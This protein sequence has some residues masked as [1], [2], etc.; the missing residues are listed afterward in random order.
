MNRLHSI[1]LLLIL[2]SLFYLSTNVFGRKNNIIFTI[3]GRQ[4]K[5]NHKNVKYD[6]SGTL[7]ELPSDDYYEDNDDKRKFIYICGNNGPCTCEK[8]DEN[9]V[10]CIKQK[11]GLEDNPLDTTNLRIKMKDFVPYRVHLQHNIINKLEENEI[12]P[13]EEE[14]IVELDL[15]YNHIKKINDD[16]FLNFKK[17]KVLKLSHNRIED[18]AN[19]KGLQNLHKLHLD[20]NILGKLPSKVFDSLINLKELVLDGNEAVVLSKKIFTEK[21]S[22]L[23]ILSID[24]CELNSLPKDLFINLKNLK[25]LSLRGNPFV[26]MPVAVNSIPQLSVLDMSETNLPE[27]DR[28][29]L[30]EDH[31]LETLYMQKM[32]Y[33]YMINDCAF[34]NLKKIKKVDFSGS[35]HI[36]HI[37]N[38][39]FGN[40]NNKKNGP[41]N[42]TFFDVTNCNITSISPYLLKWENIMA[43]RIS[44]NP[45]KCDCEMSWLVKNKDLHKTFGDEI[46][47]CEIPS[48]HEIKHIPDFSTRSCDF[49][50]DSTVWLR[51]MIIFLLVSTVTIIWLYFSGIFKCNNDNNI[52]LP[53]MGYRNLI[54]NDDNSMFVNKGESNEV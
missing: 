45:L 37:N 11:Y 40:V 28:N 17:L 13:G 1:I 7:E 54:A 39:A 4:P 32:K 14:Y 30:S 33:I 21:L 35:A 3:N 36:Y 42:I 49:N 20:N 5:F 26:S 41:T 47:T 29:A 46:P 19:F 52:E 10:N 2:F 8:S 12:M 9:T 44:G 24:Y 48:T 25:Q 31:E 53:E 15:S 50:I 23:E 16:I 22:N 27:F 38:N 43:L 51:F 6:T 18:I 34:C